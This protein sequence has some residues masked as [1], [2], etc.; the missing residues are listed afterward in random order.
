MDGKN[1][2][3]KDL[4]EL[5]EEGFDIPCSIGGSSKVD[6]FARSSV[7]DSLLHVAV[8][9]GCA[10]EVEFLLDAG[11]DINALGDYCE[12]PLF[13]A[14]VLANIELVLLL[15]R[16]GADPEIADNTGVLPKD[17]LFRALQKK[18]LAK[19]EIEKDTGTKN[20]S[21]TQP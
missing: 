18:A 10:K 12:T 19:S 5:A 13:S 16:K 4:L 7:G 9:R 1:R 3:L 15:L 11:L 17:A 2:E 21:S 6:L 8:S 20:Q 14:S